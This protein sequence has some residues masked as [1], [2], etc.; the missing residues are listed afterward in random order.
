MDE[1]EDF[2][3][4]KKR[5][6]LYIEQGNDVDRGGRPCPVA[7]LESGKIV[8]FPREYHNK[9]GVGEVWE[10]VE[11]EDKPTYARYTPVKCLQSRPKG[12]SMSIGLPPIVA[13]HI[14]DSLVSK[15]IELEERHGTLKTEVFGLREE[16]EALRADLK[17]KEKRY[18]TLNEEYREVDANLTAFRKALEKVS[19]QTISEEQIR[20]EYKEGCGTESGYDLDQDG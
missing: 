7:H 10:C 18:E 5:R 11:D 13:G 14:T 3:P 8:L 20:N 16:V 17:E 15:I 4:W 19:P 1:D 2:A 12:N 6:S 9:L